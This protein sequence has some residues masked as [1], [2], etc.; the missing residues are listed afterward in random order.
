MRG[1]AARIWLILGQHNRSCLTS[2]IYQWCLS[3]ICT[4]TSSRHL[5][6]EDNWV[7]IS[8]LIFVHAIPGTLL[9]YL[10]IK[11]TTKPICK[12]CNRPAHVCTERLSRICEGPNILGKPGYQG[13]WTSGQRTNPASC[14]TPWVWKTYA[15]SYKNVSYTDWYGGEPNCAGDKET[16]LQ[17]TTTKY[18][19][20][21]WADINCQWVL[22][23]LC[24]L[25]VWRSSDL[26]AERTYFIRTVRK[27]NVAL[28]K[29]MLTD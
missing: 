6:V 19:D 10:P 11:S 22:C 1:K 17:L 16:C 27:N 14:T 25:D 21:R 13:Y 20:Q 8:Y 15:G 18:L 12:D 29:T 3:T 23:P 26:T 24:E 7:T 5:L 9:N 2:R 28:L 4:V